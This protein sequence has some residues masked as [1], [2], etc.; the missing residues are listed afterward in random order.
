MSGTGTSS[1]TRALPYSCMRAAFILVSSFPRLVLR[2]SVLA[3]AAGNGS[4]WPVDRAGTYRTYGSVDPPSAPARAAPPTLPRIWSG[5]DRAAP[6]ERAGDRGRT[7]DVQLGKLIDE[8][9]EDYDPW[10]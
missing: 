5:P 6:S 2:W 1:R 7:G 9:P 8:G 10:A 3:S 4:P